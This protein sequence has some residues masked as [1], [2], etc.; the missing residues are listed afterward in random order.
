M[1]PAISYSAVV[2]MSKERLIG[3]DGTMPWNLPEDLKLFKD[4]TMGH[5]ILMGRKT[6]ESIGRPL[7]GRQNIVLTRQR[8]WQASDKVTVIQDISQLCEIE[9]MHPEVMVI[10]GGEIYKLLLP[11]ISCLYVS[12][13]HGDFVGD[14]YFPD[15]AAY[16]SQREPLRTFDGFELVRYIK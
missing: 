10:G 8:D 3:K 16:F 9:L 1:K 13:V 2:A 12:E 6:Y 11:Q 7:P 5:P 4:L 15:F 14:T